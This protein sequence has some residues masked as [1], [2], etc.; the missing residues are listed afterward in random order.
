MSL[1][2]GDQDASQ[3]SRGEGGAQN[4]DRKRLA[5]TAIW[6]PDLFEGRKEVC[7]VV[8]IELV[9][10]LLEA[11]SS[12]DH[13]PLTRTD[14][15]RQDYGHIVRL[16]EDYALTQTDDPLH[17]PDLC[18]AVAVSERKLQYAFEE[19][20]GMSPVAYLKRLRLHR[21]RQALRVATHGTTTVSVEALKWGFW[22]F[23]DFSYAYKTCFGELPS[24]T[25]RRKPS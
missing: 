18:R 15:T 22:H 4:Q 21:V 24:D 14:K 5:D 16:A 23:G 17:V 7:A 11:I 25:L 19:V 3:R 8:Q 13:Y 20:M 2:P 1:R 10:L 12:A 9:E 6:Q